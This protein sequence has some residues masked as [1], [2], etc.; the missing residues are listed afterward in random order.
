[1]WRWSLTGQLQSAVWPPPAWWQ[2]RRGPAYSDVI[3]DDSKLDCFQKY[4]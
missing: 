4:K 1:V 2:L 3:I